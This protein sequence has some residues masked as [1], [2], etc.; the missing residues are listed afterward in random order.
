M[1][2]VRNTSPVAARAEKL[3]RKKLLSAC[4]NE[5]RHRLLVYITLGVMSQNAR[6]WM[7]KLVD[8]LEAGAL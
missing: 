3:E 4:A 8:D 5:V 1:K 2:R 7:A 6:D